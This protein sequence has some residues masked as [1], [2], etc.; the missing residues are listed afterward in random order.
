MNKLIKRLTWVELP[1]ADIHRAAAFYSTLL[2]SK[3]EVMEYEGLNMA[4]ITTDTPETS[5]ISFGLVQHDDYQPS[6]THGALVYLNAYG[7]LDAMLAR[8]I[9]AGATLVKPR[10]FINDAV[11]YEAI[12]VDTEGN[13]IALNE[14][15]NEP[16]PTDNSIPSSF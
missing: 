3:F 15:P 16:K 6:A 1:A 12:I 11:G 9:S 4:F 14:H 13:R 8:A 2:G 10:N 5:S 7:D